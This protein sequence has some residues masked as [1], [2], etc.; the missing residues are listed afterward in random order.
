MRIMLEDY[1]DK[2]EAV[3]ALENDTYIG[4]GFTLEE[5][6]ILDR[7]AKNDSGEDEAEDDD[8]EETSEDDDDLDGPRWRL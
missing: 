3:K 8:Q 4:E 5:E 7:E 6:V 1:E 2:I